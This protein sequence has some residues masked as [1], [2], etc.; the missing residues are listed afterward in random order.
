MRSWFSTNQARAHDPMA[1][2]LR[3][4]QRRY[5]RTY[6]EGRGQHPSASVEIVRAAV[7]CRRLRATWRL[8]L[9]LGTTA[10][11]LRA[12][13]NTRAGSSLDM[14]YIVRVAAQ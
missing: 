14:R 1:L 4:L 10:T 3:I 6:L 2:R 8:E 12:L 7:S 5:E 11:L 9:Q 13:E